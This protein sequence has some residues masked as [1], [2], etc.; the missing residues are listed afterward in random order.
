MLKMIRFSMLALLFLSFAAVTAFAE[1]LDDCDFSGIATAVPNPDDLELGDY[2]YCVEVSWDTGNPFALSHADVLLALGY[3]PCACAD[4]PFG[5]ADIAGTST[6]YNENFATY[7]VVYYIAEYLCKGDP[8]ISETLGEALVKFEPDE[9]I[10][11]CAPMNHGEGTFCF[12]SDWEPRP[13]DDELLVLK[14][15]QS[16]CFGHL[17]GELPECYCDSPAL[18]ESWGTVKKLFE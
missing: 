15:G 8:S 18:P 9:E 3:C 11:S 17:V 5:S 7:C 12:Y 6:G 2:K 16:I 10:G 13:V 1:E 14:A 4:F